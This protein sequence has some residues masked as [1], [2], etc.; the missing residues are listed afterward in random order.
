MLR[1]YCPFHADEDVAGTRL[2]DGSYAFVCDRRQGHP[3]E[4][5]WRWL[6]VPAAPG[7]EVD[8]LTGLAEELNLEEVL[9]AVVAQLGSGWFEYGL[10]ER[11]YARQDPEGFKRMVEQ[12]GHTAIEKK[13]YT[14]S[15]YLAGTLGRLSSIGRVAYHP[16]KG[17]GR[18]S[19]NADIS[20]WSTLP[21]GPWSSRTAWA[22]LFQDG[23]G[24]AY[25]A[26]AECKS[27]V[28]GA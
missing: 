14:A 7:R 21:P 27:Y 23:E 1:Q 6:A 18:W 9:P 24:D 2:D 3:A 4:G 12:W 20:Y 11:A 16:G 25:L 26:D 13:R 10:V 15:S 17:T 8:G 28:P 22:D 19:Y 5:E